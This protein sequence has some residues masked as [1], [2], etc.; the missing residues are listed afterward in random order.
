M[1]DSDFDAL[2]GRQAAAQ[3]AHQETRPHRSVPDTL[4]GEGGAQRAG[5]RRA[6][7]AAEPE[8]TAPHD[9]LQDYKLDNVLGRGGMGIVYRAFDD[10]LQR[11]V[12]LK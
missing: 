5:E 12:A 10:H 8:D 1:D 6:K 7:L 11:P 4:G 9:G 2:G 3:V